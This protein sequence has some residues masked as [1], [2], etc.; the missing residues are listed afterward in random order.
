MRDKEWRV[1]LSVASP[2]HTIFHLT[3]L[4]R[5]SERYQASL[6]VNARSCCT[7]QLERQQVFEGPIE[8]A[9]VL[10]EQVVSSADNDTVFAVVYRLELVGRPTW[11]FIMVPQSALGEIEERQ[12]LHGVS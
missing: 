9:T 12:A 7:I 3:R 11:S 1:Q 8:I 2:D 4:D 5:S 10:L 6:L